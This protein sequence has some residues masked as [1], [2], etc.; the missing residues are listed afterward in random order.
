M[1]NE[2][3]FVE[4]QAPAVCPFCEAPLKR[5][6]YT[7]QKLSFGFMSGFTWVVLLT[8]PGCHKILGTQTWD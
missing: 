7:R 1:S 5:I 3:E 2:V 8:C 4:S 6:E